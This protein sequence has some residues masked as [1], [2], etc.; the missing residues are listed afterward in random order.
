MDS[1][2][3]ISGLSTKSRSGKNRNKKGV[4]FVLSERSLRDPNAYDSE[5]PTNIL[6]RKGDRDESLQEKKEYELSYRKYLGIEYE[7]NHDYEKYLVD[8]PDEDGEDVLNNRDFLTKDEIYGNFIGDSIDAQAV[9][10]EVAFM[11]EDDCDNEDIATMTLQTNEDGKIFD[12]EETLEK[13]E[14]FDDDFVKELN[15]VGSDDEIS[16]EIPKSTSKMS[17]AMQQFLGDAHSSAAQP[18]SILNQIPEDAEMDN[19]S[20]NEI[21]FDQDDKK[22]RFTNYSMTS[23]VMRR[24][25]GL[26]RI[27]NDFEEFYS[28]FDENDIGDLENQVEE[29]QNE[30]VSEDMDETTYHL[31][32][33]THFKQVQKE[34]ML[35]FEETGL[36]MR[37]DETLTEQEKNKI[38]QVSIQT[39]EI[40]ENE[41]SFAKIM[42]C[43]LKLL[44]MVA[45]SMVL[46]WYGT[47][48][49]EFTYLNV[50]MFFAVLMGLCCVLCTICIQFKL[51]DVEQ[52][53]QSSTRDLGILIDAEMHSLIKSQLQTGKRDVVDVI[54]AYKSR[55]KTPYEIVHS[56]GIQCTS[57]HWRAAGY[58]LNDIQIT[59]ISQQNL[60]L[61]EIDEIGV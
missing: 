26:A 12:F 38:K 31:L 1:Q 49:D 13:C 33:N 41:I 61:D 39:A 42:F 46:F 43:L 51:F 48:F 50:W 15:A 10:P 34:S 14:E 52:Y 36:G 3:Q 22:S 27:D 23:S 28:N 21:D 11:L 25:A 54:L 53:I 16:D 59:S 19:F 35:D 30:F 5:A 40:F 32:M 57:D 45:G 37:N 56:Y 55:H 8:N 29:I 17:Y 2:S 44:E 4:T 18:K 6:L 24:K 47:I 9:D 20:E 7:D 58:E 60:I